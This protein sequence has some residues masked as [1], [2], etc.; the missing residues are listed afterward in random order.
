MNLRQFA[1]AARRKASL[2]LRQD[3]SLTRVE[4]ERRAAREVARSVRRAARQEANLQSKL[5]PFVPNRLT[6]GS[7]VT[8]A[9]VG[10]KLMERMMRVLRSL[11][12]KMVIPSWP[13]TTRTEETSTAATART[14]ERS[15]ARSAPDVSTPRTP[16][17]PPRNAPSL[18]VSNETI[19]RA[20]LAPVEPSSSNIILGVWAGDS[21]TGATRIDHEF[22]I[23]PAVAAWHASIERNRRGGS[24]S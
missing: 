19:A 23:H 22:P 8:E 9:N 24:S 11:D 14:G 3:R 7:E 4:A 10:E 6:V 15:G 20:A 16:A 13:S 17:A 5:K 18:T 21:P 1:N 2:L 12:A